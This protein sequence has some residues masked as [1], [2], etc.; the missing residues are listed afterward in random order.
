MLVDEWLYP[1]HPS[2]SPA[3][4]VQ[5][6]HPEPWTPTDEGFARLPLLFSIGGKLLAHPTIAHLPA[7]GAKPNKTGIVHQ[8]N[9]GYFVIPVLQ[10]VMEHVQFDDFVVA[11]EPYDKPLV[12]HLR[13]PFPY[14]S[15]CSLRGRGAVMP[16]PES[17][18]PA[19]FGG[20]PS[21]AGANDTRDPRA[22]FLGSA[23]GWQNGRRQAVCRSGAKHPQALYTGITSWH[24]VLTRSQNVAE[25]ES[26][27]K[28]PK[29]LQEQVDGFRHIIYVDGYCAALRLRDLLS[30]DCTV[31]YLTSPEE[32]WYSNLIIPWQH[33][34]PVVYEP[35]FFPE[36]SNLLWAANWAQDHPAEAADIVSKA[37]AF[38]DLH[39]SELGQMCYTVRLFHEYSKLMT[40]R[41]SIPELVSY[42]R[43]HNKVL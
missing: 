29:S 28:E 22:V 34:I 11:A 35:G 7:T 23:T 37:R 8:G 24:N 21:R 41:E 10:Q 32:L 9:I 14:L 19:A 39:L 42:M 30:S 2:I 20:K 5:F 4:V 6:P 33:V 40:D 1:F 3:S 31:L 26:F 38:A 17:L 12:G 25:L 36:G 27:T 15:Y 43:K 13:P 16:M 18:R